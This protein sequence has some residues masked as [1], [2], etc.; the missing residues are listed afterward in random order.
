[1]KT[2]LNYYSRR[3]DS[4]RHPKFKMLRQ[5]LGGGDIGWAA[6]ARFW[7]LNDIIAESELCELDLSVNRNKA[8]ISEILGITLGQL[9]AFISVLLSEDV[10]LLFEI[11]SQIYSTKKV[12]D[13]LDTVLVERE[14]SRKRK[15]SGGNTKSSGGNDE[16]SGEPNNKR[17]ES[18]EKESKLNK[19]TTSGADSETSFLEEQ[20]QQPDFQNPDSVLSCVAELFSL[21]AN[22]N[23]PDAKAELEPVINH[24]FDKR[25]S[26]EQ[27]Y[28]EVIESFVILKQNQKTKT[29]YL[30][31]IIKRRLQSLY[32]SIELKKKKVDLK[33]ASELR[34][35]SKKAQIEADREFALN[36][37]AEYRQ[38]Y[39]VN[40]HVFSA[41]EKI[42]IKHSLE[43]NDWVMAAALIDAKI[44]QNIEL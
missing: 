14:K 35:Q 24:I 22:N 41:K 25:F 9:D 43:K 7:A 32:D 10:Q 6:E 42:E 17:K 13:T 40:E 36:K 27:T 38:I 20:K 39:E 15:G 18:K 3:V 33:E 26:P 30:L 4:H 37:I 16:S 8:D 11:D 19:S 1:M 12:K 5:L 23:D 2:N 21:Y 34:D 29:S 31:G 28:H 44:E